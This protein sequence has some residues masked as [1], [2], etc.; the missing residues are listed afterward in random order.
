MGLESSGGGEEAKRLEAVPPKSETAFSKLK[1]IGRSVTA[2]AGLA[3]TATSVAGED[4]EPDIAKLTRRETVEKLVYDIRK[5]GD[6]VTITWN[7]EVVPENQRVFIQCSQDGEN[8]ETISKDAVDGSFTWSLADNPFYGEEGV[9]PGEEYFRLGAET[10]EE[11]EQPQGRVLFEH[12]EAP[13]RKIGYTALDIRQLY[14]VRPE[15]EGGVLFTGYD[16]SGLREEIDN[17][18]ILSISLKS[19]EEVTRLVLRESEGARSISR[20]YLPPDG[21]EIVLPPGENYE[22]LID[23]DRVDDDNIIHDSITFYAPDRDT[24][25]H[26]E[27]IINYQN[28]LAENPGFWGGGEDILGVPFGSRTLGVPVSELEESNKS[29]P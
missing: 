16:A 24:E 29:T 19:G 23:T 7:D 3:A 22:I 1:G 13:G 21:S 28:T 10:K 11:V 6:E 20:L 14:N 9:A 27:D 5:T 12:K 2:A 18:R 15:V 26:P 25:N 8:W 4:N 17:G